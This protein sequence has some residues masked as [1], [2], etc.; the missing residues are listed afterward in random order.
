MKRD[1]SPCFFVFS[2][3]GRVGLF[4]GAEGASAAPELLE[5]E[6]EP[7]KK[8]EQVRGGRRVERASSTSTL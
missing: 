8:K 1:V 6:G 5:R 2:P 7:E 3:S 4:G